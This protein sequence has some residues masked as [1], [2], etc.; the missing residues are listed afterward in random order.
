[1]LAAA[2]LVCVQPRLA[3]GVRGGL[4]GLLVGVACGFKMTSTFFAGLPAGIALVASFSGRR[5]LSDSA[6]QGQ[7]KGAEIR[8]LAAALLTGAAVGLITLWPWLFRNSLAC[9][10]PVFPFATDVFGLAYWTPDQLARWQSAHTFDGSLLDRFRTLVWTSPTADADSP[11]VEKFRGFANPQWGLLLPLVVLAAS[12]TLAKWRKASR[13][14]A[15]LAIGFASQLVAWLALTHLQSRFLLPTLP[16]AAALVGLALARVR[17]LAEPRPDARAAA[18]LV[19]GLLVI[20]QTAFLLAIYTG[21][22]NGAPGAALAAFPAAFTGAQTSDPAATPTGWAHAR[23]DGAPLVY[24]VGEG[25]PLYYG[26]GVVYHTTY[27]TSPLGELIR[28]APDEPAAWAAALRERGIAWL[29]VSPGELTRLQRSGWYEPLVTPDAVRQ[30]AETQGGAA[31]VW[32]EMGRYLV[33]LQPGSAEP[34]ERGP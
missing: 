4:V 29:L 24:L 21:E 10:N 16:V 5:G 14:A 9:G 22:K 25:A 8:Q 33:E 11:A 34:A 2:L 7:T 19:G 15:V 26:S 18:G 27:D 3:P 31:R 30:F 13:P 32:P 23:P 6:N 12:F 17:M 28:A 1:M 20:A